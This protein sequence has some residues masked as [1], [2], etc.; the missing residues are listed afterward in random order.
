M[1]V[2]SNLVYTKTDTTIVATWTT[3]VS[4]DS[5]L[6]VNGKA[7]IDNGFETSVTSHQCVVVDLEPST[8]YPNCF[9][10]SGG[11]SSSSS[12]QSTTA[13][14]TRLPIVEIKVSNPT[15]NTNNKADTFNNALSSDA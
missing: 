1:P 11:T 4:S 8:A 15:R 7:A 14:L 6:S 9:V 3:D 10:T 13:A 5:N 2:I 12:T